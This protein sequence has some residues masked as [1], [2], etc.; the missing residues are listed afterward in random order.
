M[1]FHTT[2]V[3]RYRARGERPDVA[4]VDHVDVKK[5]NSFKSDLSGRESEK[6]AKVRDTFS[7]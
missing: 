1:E 3:A 5:L 6:K 2:H 4:T 7:V